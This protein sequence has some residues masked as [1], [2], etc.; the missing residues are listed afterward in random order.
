[1]KWGQFP[2]KTENFPKGYKKYLL[3]PYYY[4]GQVE[5][6]QISNGELK[7]AKKKSTLIRVDLMRPKLGHI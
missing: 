2:E 5:R 1:M 4:T 6:K 3:S 7:K